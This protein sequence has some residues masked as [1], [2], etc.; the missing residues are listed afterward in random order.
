[1]KFIILGTLFISL[2]HP[3][4]S[5]AGITEIK[6]VNNQIGLQAMILNV[7]YLESGNGTTSG[8]GKLDS[9]SG[10]VPGMAIFFSRMW[11]DSNAYF[12]AELSRSEGETKYVGSLLSGGSGY[13]SVVSKST[14]I[15]TDY[16]MRFGK[17]IYVGRSHSITNNLV[18]PYVELGHHE[19]FRGVNAGET[20]SH[21]F[22]GVGLLW[23]YSPMNS[24]FVYSVN[25]LAGK[26]HR[27]YIDVTGE[28]SGA[29]G[30]SSLY[31]VGLSFD[32]AIS[33]K[34]HCN[35]GAEYT[36]FAY[37]ISDT[38]SNLLEPDSTSVYIIYKAG[39]GFIF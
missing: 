15:L 11:D 14:A 21:Y 23:Q 4:M 12:E 13:G 1:M 22:Y 32:Y 39:L 25:G 16:S 18:T 36:S 2:V 29:L 28:F 7:D 38:Y 17:G 5:F 3:T 20:Y 8:T 27:S 19:W 9:E 26:S 34:I 30:N 10:G 6:T 24:K 37:G 31:K 33:K 35:A